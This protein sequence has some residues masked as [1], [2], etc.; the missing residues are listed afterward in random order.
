MTTLQASTFDYWGTDGGVQAF[1]ADDTQGFVRC[2]FHWRSTARLVCVAVLDGLHEGSSYVY[3]RRGSDASPSWCQGAADVLPLP[4][5]VLA[6]EL[7]ASCSE[8]C[9]LA[10]SLDDVA[11]AVRAAVAA[12]L[13]VGTSV[14]VETRTSP[15]IP[16][17]A[18]CVVIEGP[19]L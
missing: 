2:S 19:S 17:S 12:V 14:H 3:G 16:H 4:A 18:L 7:Y 1:R 11:D 15:H 9:V 6:Q 13:P 10:G 5:R 8:P